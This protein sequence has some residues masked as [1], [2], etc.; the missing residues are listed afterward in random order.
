MLQDNFLTVL[1]L[2]WTLKY[3]PSGNLLWQKKYDGGGSEGGFG[4]VVEPEDNSVYVAG[5]SSRGI[6]SD[7]IIVIKYDN[8]GDTVW[9]STYNA[10]IKDH[11]YSIALDKENNIY[12]CG[13]VRICS[14]C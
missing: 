10:G 12:V 4:I 8:N 11:A 3:N 2:L 1:I 6:N 13:Y 9:V 5:T 7:D 14:C